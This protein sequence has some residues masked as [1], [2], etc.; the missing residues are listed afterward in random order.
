MKK[1]LVDLYDNLLKWRE[2]KLPTGQFVL[3]L[4]LV[5]G[6]FTALAACML[7]WAI[8][9]IQYLLTTNFEYYSGNLLY[10]LYPVVGILLSGLF[11]KY[12]LRD[13]I[14]HGVTKILYAISQRKSIMKLHNV[15]SSVVASS[16]T[17][18]FGGSVGAES[19]VVLT[20]SAI[21]SNLGRFFKMDQKTL[22]LMVG[23][24]A[25]GAISGIFQAPIAGVVFTLEV[26][27]IDMTFT[28]VVPLLIS[29]VTATSLSYFLL[30][31]TV[32]F[33]LSGDDFALER[34]P[35][36]IL[37]G[38][39]CGFVSLYYTRGMNKVEGIFRKLN[40]FWSKLVVG[41][42]MLSA[43]IYLLPPL[44]GEGYDS[45]N[46]L[47]GLNPERLF[48]NSLFFSF[49]HN[50]YVIL[51][52][53]TLIVLFKLVATAAT[54]GAGGV[55]GLF[56][57]SLFVGCI[58]GYICALVL[59][60][61]G[62]DV[63][64]QNFALAGMA[65]VM[66]GI[67][68]APLT[69]IFLIAE[70]SG[71]YDYFMPLMIVSVI[72]FITIYVFEPHSIYAMR[73]AQKG[74]LMTHHKDRAVLSLMKTENVIETDLQT[75][76]PDAMFGDLIKLI[77]SSKRNIF[78]VVKEDGKFIGVVSLE[79]VRNI[80]FR[81]ELYNR[82]TVK[83]LMI[84]PPARVDINESMDSVMEK[85]ERTQAWNLPVLDGEKYVGYVSKSKIF[86][87]YRDVLVE[88]SDD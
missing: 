75:I 22:M 77:S 63:P 10:L 82:F 26:L 46:H 74:E 32:M 31:K 24:G 42:L 78:P 28:S 14:S 20:G 49:R 33:S 52:Y 44:Y 18:G 76:S 55:G 9:G 56:A 68:H 48:E 79:E 54:N 88:I 83:K 12:I 38:V 86:N 62:I 72:S 17:I 30:G 87:V 84:Y 73:L 37:L 8:H 60:M 69:G 61:C 40:S 7:K 15:W 16:V 29:S 64:A 23:C 25:A 2:S 4:S 66:S 27:M 36:Y 34:I 67:M 19:P 1:N 59:Q 3:I 57:P 6:I 5:V 21:G 58:V 39:L 41:A 13:D 81:P 53:L 43:L 71:G 51:V 80:M 65:G 47:L 45:I 50:E 70:L 11:V 85:F 35:M